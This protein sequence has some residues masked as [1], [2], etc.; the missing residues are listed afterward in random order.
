VLER[1]E[2]GGHIVFAGQVPADVHVPVP[3][4]ELTELLGALLENSVRHARRTVTV[5]A[6]QVDATLK[7]QIHDDGPG[8]DPADIA[9]A[10][11]RGRRLD[12]TGAGHG[13][14]LAIVRELVSATE[15]TL[16][17]EPSPCGGL[18]VTLSWTNEPDHKPIV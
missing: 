8:M 9:H 10:M 12:E 17:L 18:L 14:G 7:V 2:A 4:P 5:D 3:A 6:V 13:L 1:T 15:G 16:A 11:E